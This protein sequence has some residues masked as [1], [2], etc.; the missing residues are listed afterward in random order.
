MRMWDQETWPRRDGGLMPDGPTRE[1][2]AFDLETTGLMAETDREV[3][4]GA[5]RFDASGRE[6]RAPGQSRAAD[7][8]RRAGGPWPLRR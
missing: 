7:V 4:V 2:V 6:L 3:E 5:V 1:W 8:P